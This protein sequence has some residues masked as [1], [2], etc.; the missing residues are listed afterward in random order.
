MCSAYG[1]GQKLMQLL[2]QEESFP[3]MLCGVPEGCLTASKGTGA[4]LKLEGC[5]D[6]AQPW[7]LLHH[8]PAI[9]QADFHFCGYTLA[10]RISYHH[11]SPLHFHAVGAYLWGS[12]HC[13]IRDLSS[14]TGWDGFC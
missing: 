8:I 13:D 14:V 10:H 1:D 9:G 6:R 12:A 4:C 3:H 11:I 7:L 5:E 2:L